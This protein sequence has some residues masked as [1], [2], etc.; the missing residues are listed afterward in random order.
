MVKQ[1]LIL[2]RYQIKT[3]FLILSLPLFFLLMS[4]MGE[5]LDFHYSKEILLFVCFPL[6]AFPVIVF[7]NQIG[8][9]TQKELMITLPVQP[10]LF[11]VLR[12]IIISSFYAGAVMLAAYKLWFG[13]TGAEVFA[14]AFFFM[15]LT[16]TLITI[17]KNSAFG[18][19]LSLAYLFMGTFT[20]G[21]GQ[22]FLYIMQWYRPKPSTNP[23]DFMTAQLIAGIVCCLI[24]V[25]FIKKRSHFHI[26][27][28]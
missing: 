23:D 4:A 11:G 27:K 13:T 24:N 16:A 6:L 2:W 17:F 28:E 14:A 15:L 25:Y 7:M 12:P 18:I 1:E 3:N 5:Y 22:S 20:G 9:L 21:S 19:C 10:W 26:L 8:S